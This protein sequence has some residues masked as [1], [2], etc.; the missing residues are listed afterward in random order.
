[1]RLSN[2][3]TESDVELAINLVKKATL[4]SA[5]DPNTGIVDLGMLST[6][7]SSAKAK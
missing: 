4:N 2:S 1:M 7:I 5:T 6:G 3:V